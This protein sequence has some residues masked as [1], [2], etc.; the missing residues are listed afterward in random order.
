M[1]SVVV[2][3]PASMCAMI[4]MFRVLAKSALFAIFCLSSSFNPTRFPRFARK[5]VGDPLCLWRRAYWCGL[6]AVVG[7]GL[8]GFGHLVGVLTTLDA[9]TEAVAGVEDLVHEPLGHRL[10]A[11]LPRVA[12]QPAQREG[13]AAVGLDLDRH[14][15]G[16]ATDAAALHL[17]GRLHVVERALE[18]DDRVGAR[19]LPGALEGPVDDVLGERALAGEQHLVD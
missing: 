2:V 16:G 14:L 7:E 9:G 18:G 3:L 15:V 1:R 13:G 19:L 6:P 17:E 5:S 12:D 10:L 8:V 11:T 4:P